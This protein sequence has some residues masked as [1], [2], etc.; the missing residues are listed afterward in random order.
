MKHP[1][2]ASLRKEARKRLSALSAETRSAA[3]AEI[4]RR[5]AALPE[6]A[7][8]R[9][10]ALYAAQPSEPDLAPLLDAPG[11][12]T[13]FPRVS[14]DI[15]EFHRC[16]C[17]DLLLPGPWNLSEPDP[18]HCPIFPVAEIDLLLIPGL[19]FTRAGERLGRGGGFYDRFLARVQPRAVPVGICFAAQIVPAM[20]VEIHDR[21]VNLVITE[22]EV[23]RCA[24]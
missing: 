11:K 23:I 22:A 5:I 14:G 17:R 13:S 1:A 24:Q 9:A 6:W 12:T 4:C 19:A 2:K 8:A 10:V 7:A 20:P 21:Q 18:R 16:H 3:S 15:L